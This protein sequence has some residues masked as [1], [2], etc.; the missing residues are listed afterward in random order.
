MKE[1][2]KSYLLSLQELE[3][4]YEKSLFPELEYI[5]KHAL[6]QE[7]AYHSLLLRR[8]KEI[9][10][11]AGKAIEPIR[12]ARVEVMPRVLVDSLRNEPSEKGI[13]RGSAKRL[14]RENEEAVVDDA[15]R[16]A[17]PLECTSGK[18]SRDLSGQLQQSLG[19]GAARLVDVDEQDTPIAR[20]ACKPAEPLARIM[21][22]L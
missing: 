15:C 4:I 13:G 9:H 14:P 16:E 3:F 6:T 5:F 12:H 7:V 2:L 11:R 17:Q 21:H 20:M 1:E 8:R 10:A 22:V 18:S 19:D